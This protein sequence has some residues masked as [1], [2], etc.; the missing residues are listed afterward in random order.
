MRHEEIE[1]Q[2]L[3]L[4]RQPEYRPQKPRVLAKRLRLSEDEIR[5]LKR[6]IKQLV[7]AGTLSY[8]ANHLVGLPASKTGKEPGYRVT[9]VFRRA[10]A[11]FGF[12]RP[13]GSAPGADRT[14]DVFIAAS[15]A[16]DAATG[17]TVLVRLKEK[18][19]HRRP[20]PEGV[21]V[22][23]IERETHQFV[24]TYFE[25][26]GLAYVQVDGMPFSQPVLVGDP[27]AEDCAAGR[28]GR[29]RDGPLSDARTSGRRRDL[30]SARQAR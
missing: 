21:I 17:D 16:G 18:T 15:D 24:G 29:V 1:K 12:V 19:V 20:N 26:E 30:R 2:L 9:G 5:D 14:H 6:V 25:L 10:E 13:A 3:E 8:G 7:K 27:G 28:Q 4:V 22:E 11:G 23:I